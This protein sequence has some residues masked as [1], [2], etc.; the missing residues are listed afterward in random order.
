M[1]A[2]SIP[3]RNKIN[4]QVT[5]KKE[6]GGSVWKSNPP[7][8]PRR[9][10]SPALKAGK[11]TGPRSPPRKILKVLLQSGKRLGSAGVSSGVSWFSRFFDPGDRFRQI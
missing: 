2:L 3:V 6:V 11:V 8:G 9:T 7:P 1:E 5:D 4:P 10:A